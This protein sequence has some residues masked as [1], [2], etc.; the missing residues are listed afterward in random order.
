[1]ETKPSK[2]WAYVA[3][4]TGGMLTLAGIAALIGYLSLPL[5]FLFED[6]LSYEIGQI[7]AVCYFVAP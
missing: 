2:F 7:A 1:M 3:I 6:I 4:I 5:S